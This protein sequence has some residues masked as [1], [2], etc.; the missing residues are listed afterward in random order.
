M[1]EK[2]RMSNLRKLLKGENPEIVFL[3]Y[4]HQIFAL[5][6]LKLSKS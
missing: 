2:N 6:N 3:A 5:K 4:F 1:F